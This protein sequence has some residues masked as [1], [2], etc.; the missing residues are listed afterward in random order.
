MTLDL[1][2]W[3]LLSAL[4]FSVGLMGLLTRKNAV[5]L[6][7]SVEVMANA[8][9]LNLVA[10]GQHRG[11]ETGQVMALFGIALTV[12]EVVVGLAIIILI[13]RLNKTIEL[14]E[15]SELSG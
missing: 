2:H 12:A 13:H 5:A 3:M 1:T 4:M 8:V 10:I 15:I 7:L 14:D 9:N 6:L 11:D